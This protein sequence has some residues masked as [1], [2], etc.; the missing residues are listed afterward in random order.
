MNEAAN[1]YFGQEP[2]ELESLKTPT[3]YF[4][5]IGNRIIPVSFRLVEHQ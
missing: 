3:N 2:T 1:E 5:Q 4:L